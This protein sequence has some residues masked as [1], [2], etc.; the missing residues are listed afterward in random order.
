MFTF[1]TRKKQRKSDI[2]KQVRYDMH[3]HILPGID[4]GSPDVDFS[5]TLIEGMAELGYEGMICTPHVLSDL[6]PNT[7]ETISEARD[8]LT[9][10]IAHQFPGFLKGAAAEYMVDYDFERILRS[11]A[12]M[13]FGKEKYML[14][15]MSYLVESPNLRNM[16]F[17]ILTAGYRPILAH[18][19]R[20][21]Y[22]HH[23]FKE[24]EEIVEAGCELQINLPSLIGYYG[25]EIKKAA[26]KLID[27]GLIT[28]VGTDMHHQNHLTALQRLVENKRACGYIEKIS[29]LKNPDMQFDI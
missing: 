19:E 24:Y 22:Y 6:H 28:W 15:E 17:A 11:G 18:P 21:A 2:L 12:L 3:N 9:S 1:F 26:E 27:N 23:R 25:P 8:I 16:I 29:G 14:I 20:Y 7:P 10:G 13:L 4:D 5:L